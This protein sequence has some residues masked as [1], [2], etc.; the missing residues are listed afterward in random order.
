[1]TVKIEA[2]HWL[3]IAKRLTQR[4]LTPKA[5]P[6]AGAHCSVAQEKA[7]QRRGDLFRLVVLNTVSGIRDRNDLQIAET[8]HA[9]PIVVRRIRETI[10]EHSPDRQSSMSTGAS[11]ARQQAMTSSTWYRYG[12]TH[13]V[14]GVAGHLHV[15]YRRAP[16]IACA[17][18]TPP[19]PAAVADRPA[20]S[21]RA[22]VRRHRDS[23]A[24]AAHPSMR[25]ARSLYAPAR[26]S[27]W[28]AAAR[29]NR[30]SRAGRPATGAPRHR[31]SQCP[32][33]CCARPAEPARSGE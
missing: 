21:R 12:E 8:R 3:M 29:E 20:T 11:I 24:F 6:L 30:A 2:V 9:T 26:R 7:L 25:R 31:C 33:P 27:A 17:R 10:A 4:T 14:P 1:M 16:A 15:G 23:R 13:L 28:S 18:G 19:G 5:T 22:S 32:R